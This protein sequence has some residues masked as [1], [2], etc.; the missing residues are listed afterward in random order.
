MARTPTSTSLRG[1]RPP[2]APVPASLARRRQLAWRLLRYSLIAAVWGALALALVLLWFGR[3]LPRP[4][5][6]LDA[7]RRPGLTLQ[8]RAGRTFATFGDVV[9]D[10]LRLGDMPHFLSAAAVAVEDRR[11]YRHPGLDLIGI[12]RAA[13]V[14]LRAGR[15]V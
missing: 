3:D 4:E 10:P 1:G 2:A 11:F 7:A 8:D 6:A 15:L 9:G 13:F 14:N 12:A 5:T